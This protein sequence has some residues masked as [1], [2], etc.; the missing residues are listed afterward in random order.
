MSTEI[1]RV[2]LFY[3]YLYLH[4]IAAKDELPSD[5]SKFPSS[6][7]SSSKFEQDRRSWWSSS[8]GSVW[9]RASVIAVPIIGLVALVL[10]VLV[11]SHLLRSDSRSHSSAA[12]ERRRA[13]TLWRWRGDDVQSWRQDVGVRTLPRY[14]KIISPVCSNVTPCSCSRDI[15]CT[16]TDDAK[17]S[18]TVA[19]IS[20]TLH[21][22]AP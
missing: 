18:I 13:A 20:V 7:L 3:L 8:S 17:C 9:F 14:E 11:A 21:V 4:C 6:S 1:T 5:E 22:P 2:L 15:H 19:W 10:L 12:V 16:M